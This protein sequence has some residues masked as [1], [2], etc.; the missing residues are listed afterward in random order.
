MNKATIAAMILSLFVA[1]GAQAIRSQTVKVE[2][3]TDS[4]SRSY[5]TQGGGLIGLAVGHR[6]TD[7][8]FAVN[9]IINGDRARLK[10]SENHHNC[11]TL[12]V[13]IY[14]GEIKGRD[15]WISQTEPLTHKILKDHW[16]VVGSFGQVST[17]TVSLTQ[18]APVATTAPALAPPP[19]I[20]PTTAPAFVTPVAA[21]NA[22]NEAPTPTQA[23]EPS[24]GGIAHKAKQHKACLELAKDNPSIA[25]K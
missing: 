12:G 14:D 18:T 21:P 1:V 15:V 25:C 16:Q 24:L 3:V 7:V 23:P 20:P 5:I 6:N 22:L 8:V 19:F 10:C 2:V 13:G 4:E 9:V 17:Q 11:A